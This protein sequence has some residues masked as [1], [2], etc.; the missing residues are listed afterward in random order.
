MVELFD[1]RKTDIDL[2][3]AGSAS[4]IQHFRQAMQGLRAEYQI[5][6]RRAFDDRFALLRCD[7]AADTDHE[8][9]LVALQFAQATEIG[10]H[11]FLRF[12]AHRTGVQQDHIGFFRCVGLDEAFGGMEHI[13]HFVRVIL[14]H[15]ATEGFDEYFFLHGILLR[16]V[17]LLR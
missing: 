11:F 17:V 3:A 14:V 15:L 7:A 1:F 10:K 13:G 9:G 16:L 2:R 6:I 8:I 12:L 4:L 5:D